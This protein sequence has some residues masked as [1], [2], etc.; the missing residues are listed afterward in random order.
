M[1]YGLSADV[2]DQ[3]RRG[4]AEHFAVRPREFS[5]RRGRTAYRVLVAEC[6][7]QQTRADAVGP[8]FERFIAQFPDPCALAIAPESDVL[9]AWQGLGYYRRAVHLQQAAAEICQRHGGAVP[10]DPAVLAA[11][12][13]VGPYIAAAVGSI[14]FGNRAAAVDANV[15]RVLA[16]IAGITEPLGR[17]ETERTLR[18]LAADLLPD[19]DPGRWNEALMEFGAVICRPSAPRCG[20]CPV[21]G[22]CQADARGLTERIPTRPARPQRP[23]EELAALVLRDGLGRTYLLR[24][25]P[26]LLGGFWEVPTLPWAE[27]PA[28]IVTARDR[29][30]LGVAALAPRGR[31]RHEF[32]HRRWDIAVYLGA[33]EPTAPPQSEAG[34]FA[35]AEMVGRPLAGPT[36]RA[37][38]RVA[39]QDAEPIRRM[40]PGS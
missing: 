37:L 27:V 24:R 23:I 21:R 36:R 16:R 26:G 39:T 9:A 20:Q 4:I 5:W 12:P 22:V 1:R 29:F 10:S 13:G 7:L 25:P 31:I 30:G 2:R 19:G 6:M 11:L 3:V 17:P 15:R 38:Q 8:F 18:D 32:T 40:V 35:P 28:L 33:A 34:W 14:A